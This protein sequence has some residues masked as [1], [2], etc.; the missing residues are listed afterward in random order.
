MKIL[1]IFPLIKNARVFDNSGIKL[2]LQYFFFEYYLNP[3]G[4]C[5]WNRVLTPWPFIQDS[6]RPLSE[7]L[8]RTNK[9]MNVSVADLVWWGFKEKKVKIPKFYNLSFSWK[10]RVDEGIRVRNM[11]V[12]QIFFYVEVNGLNSMVLNSDAGTAQDSIM[13]PIPYW[14]FW[15]FP[16]TLLKSNVKVF[17][18]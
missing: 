12:E 17:S 1:I 18:C 9:L 3:S 8:N 10:G 11:A 6:T 7:H 14:I 5:R 4:A 13:G 16:L 2:I 15:I